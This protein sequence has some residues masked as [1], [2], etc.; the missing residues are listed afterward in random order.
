MVKITKKR[1]EN[2]RVLHLSSDGDAAI[3][4]RQ[5][6]HVVRVV[7]N[8]HELWQGWIAEDGVVGEADVCHI[9]VETLGA[10]V[11]AS[12]ERDSEAYLA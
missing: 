12:P 11:L 4:P 8:S 3:T 1:R 6:D 9:E 2:D 7:R 10:I 5:L